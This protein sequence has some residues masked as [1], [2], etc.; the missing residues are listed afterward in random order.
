MIFS[1]PTS[2]PVSAST[3]RYLIRLPVSSLIWWKLIFSRSLLA[4][5]VT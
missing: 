1:E 3:F 2:S 4:G 5:T